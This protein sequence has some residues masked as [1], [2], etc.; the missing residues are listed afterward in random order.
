M[1]ILLAGFIEIA[2]KLI[3]DQVE[4]DLEYLLNKQNEKDIIIYLHPYLFAYFTKGF[5]SLR[6][7]WLMKYK[8]WVNLVKDTSLPITEYFFANKIGEKIEL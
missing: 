7:K 4:R 6:M 2:P 1:A 3:A 5:P 8:K